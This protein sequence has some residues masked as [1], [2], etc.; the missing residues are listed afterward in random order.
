MFC[1]SVMALRWP[2][3]LALYAA[4]EKFAPGGDTVI[5]PA[6]GSAAIFGGAALLG[7]TLL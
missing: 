3:A 7:L 2:A 1:V 4:I 6:V 5:A